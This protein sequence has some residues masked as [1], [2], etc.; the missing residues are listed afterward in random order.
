MTHGSY[1]EAHAQT[2][3]CLKALAVAT[4][5]GGKWDPAWEYTYIP[6]QGEARAGVSLEEEAAVGR[7]IRDRAAIE[8][9]LK[10]SS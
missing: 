10:E 6:R 9:A 8:K 3:Q 1:K 7:S 4:K 2:C 5:A